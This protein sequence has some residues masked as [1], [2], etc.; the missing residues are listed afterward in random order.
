MSPDKN[1]R[2]RPKGSNAKVEILQGAKAAFSEHGFGDCTVSDIL[3]ASGCSRTN[4]Y[5]HFDSKEDVFKTLVFGRLHELEAELKASLAVSPTDLGLK[6]QLETFFRLF[7]NRCFSLGALAPVMLEAYNSHPEH[8]DVC[9][10]IKD[11]RID[12]LAAL[13]KNNDLP[14]VDRL[15]L[16][17]LV[18]A[19]DRIVSV[20]SEQTAPVDQKIDR[21]V[22]QA[23]KMHLPVL[24][25]G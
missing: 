19:T 18:S 13:L 14:P 15:L 22:E 4:F 3:K 17:A 9:A 12:L 6:G 5:R 2:G 11:L 21:A 10:Q 1:T 20:L 16:D 8:R 23:M 25:A 7:F 24:S